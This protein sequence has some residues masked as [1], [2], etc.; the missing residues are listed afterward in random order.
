MI[1][2]AYLYE[3]WIYS[4]A[5]IDSGGIGCVLGRILDK[6]LVSPGFGRTSDAFLDEY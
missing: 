3:Y 6:F 5:P 2:D 1:L 4:R